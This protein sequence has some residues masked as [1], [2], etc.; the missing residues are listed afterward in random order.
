MNYRENGDGRIYLDF[1]PKEWS[2][3]VRVVEARLVQIAEDR[4]KEY[5]TLNTLPAHEDIKP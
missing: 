1:E 5:L 3:V 2:Q 4:R